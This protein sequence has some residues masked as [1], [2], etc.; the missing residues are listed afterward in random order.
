VAVNR[1]PGFRYYDP[2]LTN[3]ITIIREEG[4]HPGFSVVVVNGYSGFRYHDS[5]PHECEAI[6]REEG[7]HPGFSVVV[8]NGYSGFRYYDSNP[9]ECKGIFVKK[10]PSRLLCCGTANRQTT[11]VSNIM[12]QILTNVQGKIFKELVLLIS[13]RC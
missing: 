13:K 1:H 9:H 7:N 6:I 8:V 3:V 4:N 2:V 5:N 11:Q 10:E 12:I